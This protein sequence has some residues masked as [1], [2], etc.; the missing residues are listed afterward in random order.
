MQKE[1]GEKIN[2]L[3]SSKD[4]TLKDLSEKT[5]LSVSFLSQAERG[6]TSIAIIT[7]QKIAE[8][9]GV[10]LNYF[11]AAPVAN[12]PMI[13]RSYEQS[14]FRVGESN[15]INSNLGSHLPN[16]QMDPMIVTILPGQKAE[17]TIPYEH[18]GEEFVY[19]LEGIFTVF[20]EERQYELYPGDSM[21]ISSTTPHNWANF[22]NK[23]VKIL[24]VSTPS[25][26]K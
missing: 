24:S 7:L 6:L 26:L 16:R 18:Q 15:C 4:M 25:V 19:V 8:A 5:S 2:E 14:V 12:R 13:M 9:L 10:D 17:E 3:R 11:F 23:L 1:I 22:T 21:H 20:L